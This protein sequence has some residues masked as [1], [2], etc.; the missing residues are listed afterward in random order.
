M[1]QRE[2]Q[3][4]LLL[5]LG[6]VPR[7]SPLTEWRSNWTA[8]T[9][10]SSP[11]LHGIGMS[12]KTQGLQGSFLVFPNYNLGGQSKDLN[13]GTQEPHLPCLLTCT[14]T[15][16]KPFLLQT[17]CFSYRLEGI[18]DYKEDYFALPSQMKASSSS[19]LLKS[20]PMSVSSSWVCRP[21]APE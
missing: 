12:Q 5:H 14:L 11:W 2:G 17:C 18:W 10:P 19:K 9:R 4:W 7:S 16:S 20:W 3:N 21:I 6:Q 13:P 15:L 1:C 8:F